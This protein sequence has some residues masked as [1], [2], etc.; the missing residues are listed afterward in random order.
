MPQP[1]P[2]CWIGW[3]VPLSLSNILLFTIIYEFI[4]FPSANTDLG[5]KICDFSIAPHELAQ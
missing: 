2:M 3:L 4:S 5:L 1:H